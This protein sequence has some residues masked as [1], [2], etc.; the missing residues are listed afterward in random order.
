MSSTTAAQAYAPVIGDWLIIER[1]TSSRAGVA[2]GPLLTVRRVTDK[3][4][5]VVVSDARS[6]VAAWF[7]RSVL[8]VTGAKLGNNVVVNVPA[9]LA[10]RADTRQ[11]IA[12]G[13]AF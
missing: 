6:P 8:T 11:Q 3:A 13:M 7:P 9:W 1:P 5:E 4:I 2:T 10:R 12:L